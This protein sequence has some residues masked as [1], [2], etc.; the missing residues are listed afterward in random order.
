MAER[1]PDRSTEALCERIR[2]IDAWES[3]GYRGV[4]REEHSG[5]NT[6]ADPGDLYGELADNGRKQIV[7]TS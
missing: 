4:G 2:V 6:P 7:R 1:Y 5:E 3:L